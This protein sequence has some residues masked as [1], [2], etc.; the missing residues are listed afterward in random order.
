MNTRQKKK[1]IRK[2]IPKW[3]KHI[4]WKHVIV[5]G[6]ICYG[7]TC[8]QP[9]HPIQHRYR[10]YVMSQTLM[11]ELK[12]LSQSLTIDVD[13]SSV[14]DSVK[15]GIDMDPNKLMDNL[16]KYH[17]DVAGPGPMKDLS[18]YFPTS[19]EK[20]ISIGGKSYKIPSDKPISIRILHD[21]NN[22]E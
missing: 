15:Y 16:L 9:K 18:K 2:R 3:V 22:H 8:K 7:L 13:N 4:D 14:Y 6:T 10:N 11:N 21:R 17:S 19:P 12:H 1:Y 20:Y 5:D